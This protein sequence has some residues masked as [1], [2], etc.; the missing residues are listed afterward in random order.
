MSKIETDGFLSQEAKNGISQIIAKY[1]DA[2]RFYKELNRLSMLFLN[3][4]KLDWKNTYRLVVNTLILRV[5]E[6][7]QAILLML[8]R[9]MLVPSKVLTRANLETL[10]ILAAL[11]KEPNLLQSYIDQHDEAHKRSLKAA[12]QFQNEQLKASV[13]RINIEKLYIKKKAELKG[14]KLNVLKPKQW[15][16]AASLE[17]FYNLYYTMYSNAIHSNLSALEDHVDDKPDQI[18]ISFGPSDRDLYELMQCNFY[19]LINS[20]RATALINNENISQDT[21][22]L[23]DEIRK[24]DRKY[25]KPIS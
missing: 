20:I 21:D 14:R 4:I 2:F 13:K 25:I 23:A 15:A 9:G 18:D 12:L 7:F 19:V 6:N 17:D 10:F 16:K 5:V 24:L 22:K 3:K 1:E 11:Q 8:E